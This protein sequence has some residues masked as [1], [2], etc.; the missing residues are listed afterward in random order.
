MDTGWVSIQ[1]DWMGIGVSVFD[2]MTER[3][4][5]SGLY[6]YS[7]PISFNTQRVTATV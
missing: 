2:I 1:Q 6:F 5:F 3:V 7:E 4:Y